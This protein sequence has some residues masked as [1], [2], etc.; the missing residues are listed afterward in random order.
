MFPAHLLHNAA[1]LVHALHTLNGDVL[2]RNKEHLKKETRMHSAHLL[3]DAAHL[4]RVLHTLNGDVL[5]C[6]WSS[7][8]TIVRKNAACLVRICNTLDRDVLARE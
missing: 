7:E 6:M 1:C 8:R 2:C 5:A 4:V 3:H